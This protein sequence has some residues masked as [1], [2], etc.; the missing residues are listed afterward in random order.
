M[1]SCHL[2]NMRE[3]SGAKDSRSEWERQYHVHMRGFNDATSDKENFQGLGETRGIKEKTLT[4]GVSLI[5]FPEH[6]C[7]PILP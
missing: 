2:G 5:A 3:V 4:W 6:L 1:A 7:V